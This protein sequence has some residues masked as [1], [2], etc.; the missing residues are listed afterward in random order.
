MSFIDTH[1]HLWDIEQL[2]YPWLDEFAPLRRTFAAAE[3]QR[4]SVELAATLGPLDGVVVV[5]ADTHIDDAF[6]E[7][8]WVEQDAQRLPL[9]GMVAYAPLERG[10]A[11]VEWLDRLRESP[12]VR[13]VRRSVQNAPFEMITDPRFL[14]GLIEATRAGFAIDM[15]LRA[16]QLPAVTALLSDLYSAEPGARVVLD[17]LAKPDYDPTGVE[18]WKT[19][20][21]DTAA[22]PGV[23]CKVSGALTQPFGD[24]NHDA[25]VDSISAVLE[26]F[27]PDRVMVGGDWPVVNLAGGLGP[28]G[29]CVSEAT[30]PLTD[31][32]RERILR[33]TASEFYQLDAVSPAS[34][35]PA[36][37]EVTA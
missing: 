28:W 10:S 23:R 4:E 8:A 5:Q 20:I 37:A 9:L 27:G 6:D 11:V 3:Y 24:V 18:T 29:E 34:P 30:A 33:T 7:I 2:R 15:C 17:H 13:G 16:S 1:V 31:A 22:L 19:L 32:D 12:I 25:V 21:R 36:G 14:R 35:Y 26:L